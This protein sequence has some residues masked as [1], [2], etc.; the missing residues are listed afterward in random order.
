MKKSYIFAGISILI[1]ST[2]A[3]V[4]KLLL[5]QLSNFQVLFISCFFAFLFLLI[6][7]IIT[8]DIKILKTYKFKDYIIQN[9]LSQ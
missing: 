3:T 5:G 9:E 1:W 2:I 8:G 7:S 4:S 6:V